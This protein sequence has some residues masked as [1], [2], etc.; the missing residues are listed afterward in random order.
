MIVS[1]QKN[2]EIKARE[3]EAI[4]Q[5]ASKGDDGFCVIL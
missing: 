2:Y 4:R 3:V 1:L 5:E